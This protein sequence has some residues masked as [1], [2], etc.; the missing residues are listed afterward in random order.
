MSGS[1]K[2]DAHNKGQEDYSRSGGFPN[3]NPIVELIHPTYDPPSGH[4]DEYA[5]GWDNAKKQD[6]R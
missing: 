6:S 3:D 4:A 1:P 2:Q 5:S